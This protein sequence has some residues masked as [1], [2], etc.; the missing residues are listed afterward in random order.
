MNVVAITVC[1]NFS[2]ILQHMI[3]QNAKFLKKWYIVTSPEDKET[4]DCVAAA[5]KPN[6]E[7][8]LYNDFYTSATFNK[9]GALLF[10]QQH[11]DKIYTSAN[12]L[13]LDSDIYLP[14]NFYST[15]P[16]ALEPDTVYGMA[17]R[18]DY[19]TLDDFLQE[20]NPR[21]HGGSKGIIG[22]FQLYKQSSYMYASSHNCSH[23]DTVFADL[24]PKRANLNIV[25]KHLGRS[26]IHWNGRVGKT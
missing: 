16:P 14:D 5:N 13:I 11:I 8:L 24:F 1:V 15:L 23:C 17:L 18:L 4:I 12:I 6:M 19:W 7:I 22:C 10:A 20:R 2:D 9:G 25:V 26:M 21:P 3:E